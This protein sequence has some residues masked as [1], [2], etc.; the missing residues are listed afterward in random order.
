MKIPPVD[1]I[2]PI[3]RALDKAEK[4]LIDNQHCRVEIIRS[5][6]VIDVL[7]SERERITN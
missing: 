5:D 1:P 7:R 3:R 6:T 4:H 2:E